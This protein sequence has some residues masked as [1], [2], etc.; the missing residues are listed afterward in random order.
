MRGVALQAANPKTLIF[1][2]ALLP[3][4]IDASGAIAPQ[5]AIL[6]ATSVVIEFIVLAVYGYAAARSAA[7]A[8]RPE[9]ITLI[10]RLSGGMLIAVGAGIAPSAER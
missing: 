8:H 5:V 2:V 6:G 4:F 3:L 1:F 7:V 10:N 9:F